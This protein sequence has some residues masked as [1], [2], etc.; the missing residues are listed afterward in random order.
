ML[1]ELKAQWVEL[2]GGVGWGEGWG[3]YGEREPI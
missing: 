3:G 1:G 2:G